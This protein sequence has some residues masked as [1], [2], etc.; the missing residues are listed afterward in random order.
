MGG[1]GAGP[2]WSYSHSRV[3]EK[4]VRR[5]KEEAK[6]GGWKAVRRSNFGWAS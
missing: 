3:G 4:R 5:G 1:A 2:R 6:P